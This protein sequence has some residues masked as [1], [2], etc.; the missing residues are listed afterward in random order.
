METKRKIA[1]VVPNWD[2][3]DMLATCLRSLENQTYTVDIIVVD[4]G[5]SDQSVPLVKNNFPEVMILEL[6]VNR[7]FTGGVNVGIRYAL[8]GG[9]DLIG[10]FNNDAQAEKNWLAEL[11]MAA[12][13]H[14]EAGIITGKFMSIDK[15][16]IDSAGEQFHSW[17]VPSSRGRLQRDEGQF[18]TAGYVFGASGGA[19]LYRADLFRAIGLF[20]ED[21]FAYGEDADINFRAQLAGWK[22]YYQPDA[23][24]YHAMSATSDRINGFHAYHTMKNLPFI[25]WKNVP[26]SMLP[27]CLVRFSIMYVITLWGMSRRGASGAAV[28]GALKG[29]W[30]TPKKLWQ[31]QHIQH[32]RRVPVSYLKSIIVTELPPGVTKLARLLTALHIREVNHG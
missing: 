11:V 19:T 16:H 2:G 1:I 12:N 27:A 26:T 23:V 10:L 30:L 17:G 4:N 21:F 22:V 28:R 31:R 7:G 18:D 15:I 13:K 8:T 9:Y 3:E 29:L 24:A 14:P 20:D 32:T 6:P 5:S 25:V